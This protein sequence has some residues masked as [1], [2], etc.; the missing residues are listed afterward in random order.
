MESMPPEIIGI[1]WYKKEDYKRIVSIS[2][3]GNIF[4]PSYEVWL[5]AAEK[6]VRALESKGFTVIKTEINPDTFPAWCAAN[7]MDIN[8]KARIAFGNSK[9]MEFM[10]KKQAEN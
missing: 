7:G 5:A 1:A 2:K 6:H 9:A 3:D 10:K 4:S 8:G